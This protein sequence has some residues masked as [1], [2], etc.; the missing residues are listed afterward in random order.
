MV[1]RGSLGSPVAV[2]ALALLRVEVAA[3]AVDDQLGERW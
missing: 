2:L 1:R 3:S